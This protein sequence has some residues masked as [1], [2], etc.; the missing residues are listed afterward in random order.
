MSPLLEIKNISKSFFDNKVL[1][2]VNF[3]CRTNEIHALIGENGAGK[4]TLVNIIAGILQRDEGTITFDGSEVSFKHP[5]EAMSAGISLMHQELS[6]IPNVT[7]TENIYLRRE[8][9]T[10]FGL[11]DWNAMYQEAAKVFERIGID[12]DPKA[13]VS[14][15][16]VGM[17]QLVEL[18]KAIAIDAKLI[19]MDEPT[20]SLSVKETTDFFK[21]MR[22]LKSQGISIIFISHKLSELFEVSDRITVLRDGQHISTSDIKSVTESDIIRDMV[23]RHL[24]D[25]YPK[26]SSNISKI[27]FSCRNL[28]RF[29]AVRPINFEVRAGEIVGVAGLVG[30]GR[31]E[32]MRALINADK[33]S[34]GSFQ[35]DG[36]EI[37]IKNPRDALKCGI[38][39]LSEDRKGSG[40]F[41][42]YDITANVGAAAF[43][44]YTGSFGQFQK[45]AL[46]KKAVELVK[47]LDIRPP[48]V[49]ALVITLSGGNQQKVLLAKALEASPQLLIVDEPTRGVDVGA[50]LLIHEQLRALAETGIGVVVI[51]SEMSE[52]IGMSHRILVFR[53]GGIATELDNR[54]G[55][56][57]QE[58]VMTHAV[59]R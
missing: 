47:R 7:V 15:L 53:N 9:K 45:S 6:L 46:R 29:G 35:I 23:G 34:S 2:S 50:K 3:D 38:V 56:V 5:Q 37:T 20:S 54:N 42:S 12:I 40:L 1:R 59:S 26:R 18:A 24:S 31:T 30:A 51:S 44:R 43:D 27:I 48:D 16:S 28:S 49:S 8:K 55:D 22:E 58:M 32:A 17:Q 10:R 57:S 19:I 41:L 4:S 14:T 13:L 25:L 11:N 52:V 39:Y 21:V 36:K 33:R